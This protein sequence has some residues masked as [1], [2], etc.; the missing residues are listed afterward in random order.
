MNETPDTVNA[1]LTQEQADA[2]HAKIFKDHVERLMLQG[3]TQVLIDPRHPACKVPLEHKQKEHLVLN[4]SWKFAEAQTKLGAEALFTTLT[5]EGA[6]FRCVLPWECFLAARPYVD[7]RKVPVQH[8]GKVKV[9]KEPARTKPATP[10]PEF[11]YL[12]LVK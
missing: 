10:K 9:D 4:L 6:A 12:R 11:A 7:P 1:P 8:K 3:L 5:F 2:N